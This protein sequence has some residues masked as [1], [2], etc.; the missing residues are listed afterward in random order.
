MKK[1][2]LSIAALSVSSVA[3]SQ[4]AVDAYRFSQPDLKGTARFMSMGGAFGALGGDLSTL[5]QNPAGIGVYRSN[6]IGI[7]VDLDMQNAK[8]SSQGS[9]TSVSQTKFL[10]NNI[11]GVATLRLPSNTIPNLNLGFTFNKGTSFNRHYRGKIP[12]LSVSMSNYIAG[13]ANNEGLSVADVERSGSYDPYNPTD[14]GIAA[15]WLAILGYD[16]YLI[17]P[18]GDPN[19]PVWEGQWGNGTTGAGYFDVIESGSVEEYNIAVGGNIANKVYW[20]MNF[21]IINFD[22]GINSLWGENLDGAY[23]EHVDDQGKSLG[24]EQTTSNWNLNNVYSASGSGF[25]YSL[26][27]IVKPIQEIRLGFAFHTP[28]WYTLTEDFNAWTNMKYFGKD[29]GAETNH[30]IPGYNNINF[31]SPW[32]LSAS[33]AG[34]IGSKFIIS[35]DN[36][37][38]LY[39]KMKFSTPND[40]YWDYDYGYDYDYP[41][42][43]PVATRSYD[44]YSETNQDVK[45]IYKTTYTLRLGAEFRVTPSFSVRAGYSFVTSPV[46]ADAKDDRQTIYTSGTMPNYRFDNMTNYVT[47]G[48]GYKYKGFYVDLAYVFKKMDSEYHAFTPDPY[49]GVQ[50]PQSKISFNSSQLVLSTGI[51]F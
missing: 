46:K 37:W 41:W 13:I 24:I 48:V 39:N 5:S 50:S 17:N 34:V 26:G 2:Y 36:E 30:G 7:T 23:V 51:R 18:V 6:E 19:G 4:S 16:S 32:R 25:K 22:Y 31:S 1:L 45:N 3:F 10:L 33:I 28:T 11:G 38:A 8:S 42:Y 21:D 29:G 9:S 49:S 35:M 12:Q 27:V 43:A 47:C 20:G 44:P 40:N 15:P 14:G